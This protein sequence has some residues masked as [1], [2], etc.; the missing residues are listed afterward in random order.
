MSLQDYST[1][2]VSQLLDIKEHIDRDSPNYD[3]LIEELSNRSDEIE[4]LKKAREESA[5]LRVENA[6]RLVGALQIAAAAVILYYYLSSI[7]Y[8]SVSL[9]DTVIDLPVI[10]LNALA[11]ITV[12]REN[13]EYY[14]VSVLN[15]SLQV[16]SLALGSIS[17]AY[18][19]LGGLYVQLN[20]NSD[21]TF[22]TLGFEASFSPGVSFYQYVTNLPAQNISIDILAILCIGALLTVRDSKNKL[23]RTE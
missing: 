22:D 9:L 10:T 1:H 3:A 16:P 19:G 21:Y 2:S 17:A 7:F 8:G 13:Y 20:W 12:I 18:S 11:G 6:V 23:R 15:Q 5:F 14:W 4:E